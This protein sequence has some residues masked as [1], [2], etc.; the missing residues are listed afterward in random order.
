MQYCLKDCQVQLFWGNFLR[1]PYVELFGGVT[2]FT[3]DHFV[4][5]NGY[6]NQYYGW[7]GEDDDMYSR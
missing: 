1:L 3:S 6:S 4:R 5:V 7:G 2:A